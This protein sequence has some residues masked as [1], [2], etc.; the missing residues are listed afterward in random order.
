MASK[1]LSFCNKGP[2]SVC[3]LSATGAVSNADISYPSASGGVLRCEGRYE[4]LS[5]SGSYTLGSSGR[6]KNLTLSVSL[7]RSDGTIYGGVVQGHLI[8]AAPIQVRSCSINHVTL[9]WANLITII[10][11]I[12]TML[13]L[14]FDKQSSNHIKP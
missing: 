9:K 12:M 11:T 1:I 13:T 3:I 10:I 4:I 14:V 7:A 5:L 2:R 6:R 8:A